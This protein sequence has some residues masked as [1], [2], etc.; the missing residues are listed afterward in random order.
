MGELNSLRRTNSQNHTVLHNNSMFRLADDKYKS[1]NQRRLKRGW[2]V[3]VEQKVDKCRNF[4]FLRL[5]RW[6]ITKGGLQWGQTDT[7]LLGGEGGG[8]EF[9]TVGVSCW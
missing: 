3:L 4:S 6:K 1:K 9:R 5:S 8:R 2:N 7:G